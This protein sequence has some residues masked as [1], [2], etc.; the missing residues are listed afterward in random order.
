MINLLPNE[1]KYQIRA[2]RTNVL[3]LRYL[4]LSLIAAAFLGAALV[5]AYFVMTAAKDTAATTLATNQRKASSFSAV[6]LQASDFRTNLTTAKTILDNQI[7][8]SKAILAI[9]HA[10]PPNIILG[11]LDL[12]VSAFG[13]PVSLSAKAKSYND[14][15]TLKDTLQASSVFSNVRLESVSSGSGDSKG[16][17]IDVKINVTIKKEITK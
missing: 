13:T 14:A 8:Y 1:Y 2:A 15:L 7:Y 10:L 11:N 4:I 12:D 16:Y 5:G 9:A 17:P 3:L 6:E